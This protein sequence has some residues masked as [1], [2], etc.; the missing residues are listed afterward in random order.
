MTVTSTTAPKRLFTVTGSVTDPTPVVIYNPSTK[1][2]LLGS[3]TKTTCSYPLPSKSSISFGV[4]GSD[5]I[6]ARLTTAG[7][8]SVN[9]LI[10]RQ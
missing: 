4:I 10:G 9:V 1:T 2:I 8:V 3:S 6:Y 5:S 7:A